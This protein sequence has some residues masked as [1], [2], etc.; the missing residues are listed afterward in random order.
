MKSSDAAIMP[1]YRTVFMY[2]YTVL[3]WYA[4]RVKPEDHRPM[5]PS[6]SPLE[7]PDAI[8][9]PPW[10]RRP[11]ARA[12]PRPQLSREAIVDAALRV[13]DAEGLDA[14]SMRRV[15][16]EAGA[17][18][19][20]LYWHVANKEQLLQLIFDRVVGEIELPAPD[21]ARWQEQLKEMGRAWR[22]VQKRHRDVARISLGR[23]PL[24]PNGLHAMEWLL[25][26]LRTAGL[27]DRTAAFAG[28]LLTLYV[29]AYGFEESTAAAVPSAEGMSAEQMTDMLRQYFASLPAER[30]PNV[31]ALA[32]MMM[33]GD[34]DERF[35]FGLDLLVRGLA[36]Q[37]AKQVFDARGT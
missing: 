7:E 2:S 24:G 13:L 22:G 23:I 5:S 14:L 10:T 15:A 34:A 26:L 4:V 27:P 20:S 30:F 35:E 29:D 32:G 19:T 8:P 33:S 16:E 37:V 17:G 3:F 25:G 12:A 28:D 1:P 18:T 31:H 6:A 9:E 11:P 36:A 21:P